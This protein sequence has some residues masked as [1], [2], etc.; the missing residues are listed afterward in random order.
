MRLVVL[1]ANGR[2][3]RHVLRAALDDGIEVTAVVRCAKKHPGIRHERLTVAF[4]D[5]CDAEFLRPVFRGQDA[6]IST[7]GGR[8]PTKS[9]TSVYH[10]SAHAMA[11][12]GSATGLA[13][14]VVTS[15]ALLF[16][17]ER[18]SDRLLRRFV[19][20][21]V[22]SA[23]RMEDILRAS[24]LVWTFAR[25]GFLNDAATARYRA[26][27]GA[28]PERG[29]SVS[30]QA[31]A[32]FLVDAAADPARGGRVFGVSDAAGQAR[33]GRPAGVVVTCLTA[34]AQVGTSG[35][36]TRSRARPRP[37]DL[38]ASCRETG[39]TAPAA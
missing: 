36:E 16:P 4:G 15:T 5:P 33:T 30:R 1:G 24:G 12:A 31:L 39:R 8:L 13:R 29:R 14:A 19:P 6:I 35:R 26:Q 2:T 28:L 22:R 9:A 10:R 11:D 32:R 3:G 21:V 25:C 34:D 7:L 23:T 27:V 20:N 38:A 17:P 37:R 18:L